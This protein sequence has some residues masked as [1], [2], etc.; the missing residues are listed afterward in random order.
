MMAPKGS[1]NR[2]SVIIREKSSVKKVIKSCTLKS[3]KIKVV[4]K[5]EREPGILFDSNLPYV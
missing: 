2:V 1:A 4:F 5:Y 3:S